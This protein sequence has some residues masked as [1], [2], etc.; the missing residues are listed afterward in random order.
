[1]NGAHLHLLLNHVPVLGIVF[2]LA[3]L[4]F[5]MLRKDGSLA[6]VSLGVFVIAR[7]AAGAVYLTGESAEDVVEGLPD[8]SEARIEMHEDA[9]LYPLLASGALGLVGL[10]GLLAFRKKPLPTGFTA[11]VLVLALAASSVMAWTANLG[12]Q[13]NHPEIR[14]GAPPAT[15]EASQPVRYEEDD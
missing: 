14:S 2:G 12:G 6:R 10:G 11:T 4:A 8:V 15:E 5:A 9:G 7:L 13:I 3:L 1:M